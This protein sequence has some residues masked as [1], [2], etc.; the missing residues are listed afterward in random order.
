ML[1]A[2]STT[3]KS[4]VF[5]AVRKAWQS[6]PHS[7]IHPDNQGMQKR[8]LPPSHLPPLPPK[9]LKRKLH[10]SQHRPW[11][12]TWTFGN[13]KKPTT[14]RNSAFFCVWF[15]QR[16]W[17]GASEKSVLTEENGLW[18]TTECSLFPIW[19]LT[20]SLPGQALNQPKAKLGHKAPAGRN[21]LP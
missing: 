5:T 12:G 4:R 2:H 15:K 16:F 20:F 8:I 18:S 19:N 11:E 13:N 17:T 14:I 10:L 6:A 1:I 3:A 7:S 9:P 21:A